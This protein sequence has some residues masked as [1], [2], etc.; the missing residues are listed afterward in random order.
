MTKFPSVGA[1][2]T[3]IRKSPGFEKSAYAR[4]TLIAPSGVLT[5][6]CRVTVTPW[7]SPIAELPK[8]HINIAIPTATNCL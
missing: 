8:P 6:V 4:Y 3:A 7:Y 2:A 1:P 5:L